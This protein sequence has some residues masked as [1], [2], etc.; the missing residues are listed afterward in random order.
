LEQSC[1]AAFALELVCLG[2]RVAQEA[3][4]M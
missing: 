2:L 4:H 1:V 3:T